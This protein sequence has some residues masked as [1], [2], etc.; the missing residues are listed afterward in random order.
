MK[1]TIII[2]CLL[3]ILGSCD[4]NN[5]NSKKLMKGEEWKV[6]SITVNG[7][8][9]EA[10]G[11]WLVTQDVNIYDSI[12]S[13]SW[14]YNGHTV[15]FN[16]QFRNKAKL[17]EIVSLEECDNTFPYL[18]LEVYFLSGEYEVEK[19]SRKQMI[20]KSTQTEGYSGSIVEITITRIN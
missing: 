18:E 14:E 19:R 17:F 9:I 7:N 11:T 5:W 13:V 10:K 8:S 15:D 16:W 12:P 6:E 4:K 20:F 3:L 1:H 2:S